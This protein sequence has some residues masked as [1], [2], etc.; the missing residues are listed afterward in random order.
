LEVLAFP[1]RF[2]VS[3]RLV[4]VLVTTW[5]RLSRKVNVNL[6]IV[7][8]NFFLLALLLALMALMAIFLAVLLATV[9]FLNRPSAGRL[10]SRG[11]VIS[12]WRHAIYTT[13]H[14]SLPTVGRRS[15]L[16]GDSKL[17]FL[18]GVCEMGTVRAWQVSFRYT[19]VH[20]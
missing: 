8:K 16:F 1:W 4:G 14:R 13:R 15:L 12:A 19:L 18:Q 2:L 20:L 7:V 11:D 6:E 10:A 17:L 5:C 3:W 9:A